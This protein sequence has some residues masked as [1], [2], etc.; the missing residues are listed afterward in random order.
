MRG[1]G[2]PGG[3]GRALGK[4]EWFSAGGTGENHVTLRKGGGVEEGLHA[5]P[6]AFKPALGRARSGASGS[7]AISIAIDCIVIHVTR[8]CQLPSGAVQNQ[9]HP[10]ELFSFRAAAFAQGENERWDAS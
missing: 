7:G 2:G 5:E 6:T 3:R 4:V 8:F 9:L 10:S 1:T